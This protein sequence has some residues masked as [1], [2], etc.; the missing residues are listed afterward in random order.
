MPHVSQ[1]KIKADI[2]KKIERHVISAISDTSR[3]RRNGIFREII[4]P[5]EH[6]MIAK[7]FAIILGIHKSTPTHQLARTLKVSPSTVARYEKAV[8]DGKYNETLLFLKE[9]SY[10]PFIKL[11]VDLAKIPFDAPKKSLNQF[12]KEEM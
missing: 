4:T 1:H 9:N 3:K 10:S 5:T 12:L 7:R 6:L 8:D 11:L 2:R